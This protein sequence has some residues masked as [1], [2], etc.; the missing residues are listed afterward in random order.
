[1]SK[2]SV[3]RGH[4]GR[5][6]SRL[7]AFPVM[8]LSLIV[9]SGMEAA[10]ERLPVS[11]SKKNLSAPVA[12][13]MKKIDP[14]VD[15]GWDS[16]VFSNAATAQ[17]DKIGKLLEKPATIDGAHLGPLTAESFSCDRLR[18]AGL[19]EVFRDGPIMVLRATG[20]PQAGSET[21][22]RHRGVT[23]LAEALRD[24]E[25]GFEGAADIR[26]KLKLFRV[27]TEAASATTS[28]YFEMSGST[29]KGRLERTAIWHIRWV[30]PSPDAPPRLERIGVESYEEVRHDSPGTLFADSTES[31][32]GHN[33]SYE[34]QMLVGVDHW[35]DRIEGWIETDSF[36]HQGLALGDVNG[37]GLEDLYACQMAGLPNRLFVQNP[38][39]TAT[40]VSA[41]SGVDWLDATN[42]VLLV[43]LD[44]DSDQDLVV[45]THRA[46]LIMENDGTGKFALRATL[47]EGKDMDSM[48]AADYDGDGFVDLFTCGYAGEEYDGKFPFPIP[49]YDANNGR[50]NVLLKNHGDWRF[51]D[52]TR[53][54]GLDVN[55][56]RYSFAAAFEDYDND[57]D[58]DLYVA[59][60]FG[61][62]NLYR[63]DSGVFT[64]VAADASV[65]DIAAGM[66][67]AWADYNH[68]GLM[69]LYVGNMFSSAGS[70]IT[71]QRKFKQGEVEETKGYF[72]RHAR[73]NSLFE[74][75]GDGTFRDVSVEAAVTMG[76]WAWSSNFLDLNNDG[77]DDIVVA[78]GYFTK[79]DTDDL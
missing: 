74:N 63:N 69:D 29:A 9:L 11:G 23:G 64:D 19:R 35:L 15:T 75:M 26:A 59:N 45:T 24:L 7:T 77:W 4:P 22:D 33:P 28:A 5:P 61:R 42:S 46:L 56:R 44:N 66:S 72:Q 78:N 37:D 20:D 32:L 38:D 25:A 8:A 17:L 70:R 60:D 76:R 54:S 51:T 52:V 73:G 53:E 27:E 65:E 62:N 31:V 3:P 1:M 67:V 30:R 21:G 79:E 10:E 49:Y 68:D 58:V 34:E 36:G 48:T 14:A 47:P 39:G 18:P 41:G 6:S 40:D 43:D 57:G 12:E 50:P 16:E 71:Y 2:G 55:N 13:A